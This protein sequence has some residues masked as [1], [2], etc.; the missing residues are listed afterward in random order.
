[1][2]FSTSAA[3]SGDRWLR[4][5][6]CAELLGVSVAVLARW[7]WEGT[8]PR[9]FKPNGHTVLYALKDVRA[10]VEGRTA[11]PETTTSAA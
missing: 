4:T 1:M 2:D 5:R 9:F 11:S 3:A 6:Q 8:G 7:R 10:W